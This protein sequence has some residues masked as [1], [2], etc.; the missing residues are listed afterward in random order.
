MISVTR[1][2]GTPL[3]L[4]AELIE[5]VEKTPDT[6]VSLATGNRYVVRETVEEVVAKVVEYRRRVNAERSAVNPIQGFERRNP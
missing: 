6:V 3:T 1:L 5:T 2:N 4:N